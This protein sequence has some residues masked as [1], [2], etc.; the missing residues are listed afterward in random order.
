MN[1]RDNQRLVT[2]RV[3]A[4]NSGKLVEP[5]TVLT[6]FYMDVGPEILTV[7]MHQRPLLCML[8]ST[9]EEF[10]AMGPSVL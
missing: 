10:L 3:L 6:A 9:T 4:G 1:E 2:E 8:C 5:Q 7:Q